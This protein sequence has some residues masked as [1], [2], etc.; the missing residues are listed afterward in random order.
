MTKEQLNLINGLLA[1]ARD[2]AKLRD[3][4]TD[5]VISM[6]CAGQ[7]RGLWLVAR[8]V[9]SNHGHKKADIDRICGVKAP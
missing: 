7:S 8:R 6:Y 5:K 1:S 3:E 9:M 4:R 2:A